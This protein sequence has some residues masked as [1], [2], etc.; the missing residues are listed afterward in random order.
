MLSNVETDPFRY[1]WRYV[2]VPER[3]TAEEVP[4]TLEDLIHPR[5]EDRPP[6]R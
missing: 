6:R 2:R 3:E 5:L 1:G 4:L